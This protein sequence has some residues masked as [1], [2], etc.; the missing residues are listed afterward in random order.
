M[1]NYV[2]E[3]IVYNGDSSFAHSSSKVEIPQMSIHMRMD[4][5]TGISIRTTTWTD[6]KN[7][8]LREKSQTQKV[9]IVWFHLYELWS[10]QNSSATMESRPALAWGWEVRCG[11]RLTAKGQKN[12]LWGDESWYLVWVRRQL[13]GCISLKPS[14]CTLKI[15]D[16]HSM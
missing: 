13:H 6:H 7:I 8:M 15:A 3:R 1:T 10:R 5:Q 16:F 4:T 14:Y 2:Q 11:V 12:S 9:S